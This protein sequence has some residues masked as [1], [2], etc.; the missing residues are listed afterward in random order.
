LPLPIILCASKPFPPEEC[1]FLSHASSE[2]RGLTLSVL[3]KVLGG[4]ESLFRPP[5]F[6]CYIL[7]WMMLTDDLVFYPFSMNGWADGVVLRPFPEL[8]EVK[9]SMVRFS[10]FFLCLIHPLVAYG[11]LFF[12][13]RQGFGLP[14]FSLSLFL[15][16]RC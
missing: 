9:Y 14:N 5:G 16:D 8:E 12:F 4:L 10:F 7:L 2:R 15:R 6:F 3:M 1:Y 11:S 13:S